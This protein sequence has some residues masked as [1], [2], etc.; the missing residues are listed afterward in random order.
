MKYIGVLLFMGIHY[1]PQLIN[2]WKNS[3]LYRNELPK[4]ISKNQFKL[5]SI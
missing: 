4:Y 3:S 5:L 2:Y 1:L